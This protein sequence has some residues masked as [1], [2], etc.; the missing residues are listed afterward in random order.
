[1]SSR[2][3]QRRDD[4]QRIRLEVEEAERGRAARRRRCNVTAGVALAAVLLVAVAIATATPSFLLGRAG[5]RLFA[6]QPES[7]TAGAFIRELNHLIG[8]AA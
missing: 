5:Q 3:A 1:M 2:S 4:L 8:E 6:F 7:L